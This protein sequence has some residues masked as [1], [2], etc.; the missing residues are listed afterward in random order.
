MQISCFKEES[1][2]NFIPLPIKV[3][4]P[5]ASCKAFYIHRMALLVPK[6]PQNI[7]YD[8]LAR[9]TTEIKIS[10][11]GGGQLKY[12]MINIVLN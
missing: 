2:M 9:K 7:V 1:F 3:Q 10:R 6:I 5:G 8:Y 12:T 11:E 4:R